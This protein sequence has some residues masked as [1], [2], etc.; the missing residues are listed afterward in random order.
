FSPIFMSRT[1]K[2]INNILIEDFETF[3]NETLSKHDEELIQNFKSFI[4]SVIDTNIPKRS[5]ENVLS[6]IPAGYKSTLNKRRFY[7]WNVGTVYKKEDGGSLDKNLIRFAQHL[8]PDGFLLNE[9]CLNYG[10]GTKEEI[11]KMNDEFNNNCKE[12]LKYTVVTLVK[13]Q[14]KTD[15]I[16]GSAILIR[17]DIAQQFRHRTPEYNRKHGYEVATVYDT[18]LKVLVKCFY[19]QNLSTSTAKIAVAESLLKP[20]DKDSVAAGDYNWPV[21]QFI[22]ARKKSMKNT[23]I[24]ELVSIVFRNTHHGGGAIFRPKQIDYVFTTIKERTIVHEPLRPD[25]GLSE[26]HFPIPF[27]IYLDDHGKN[28]AECASDCDVQC[29]IRR[30]K[31]TKQKQEMNSRTIK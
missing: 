7:L 8:Q 1:K 21:K 14:K 18:K 5:F 12:N 23:K 27:D 25:S 30:E 31:L 3:R 15:W 20:V 29:K 22:E 26:A 6:E 2:F 11:R 28:D 17:N 13:S 4:V 16:R 19:V 10:K 9:L 24:A